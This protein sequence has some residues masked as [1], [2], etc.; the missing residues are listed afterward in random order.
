METATR[1]ALT[2]G[3]GLDTIDT[4]RVVVTADGIDSGELDILEV[5]EEWAQFGPHEYG[6][7]LDFADQV[8]R[9]GRW[10]VVDT[11][12]VCGCWGDEREL[13]AR[14]AYE[15]A[16]LAKAGL[17]APTAAAVI[18]TLDFLADDLG[19]NSV[20]SVQVAAFPSSEDAATVAAIL[21]RHAP[22]FR[23]PVRFVAGAGFQVRMGRWAGSVL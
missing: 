15:A 4:Y 10:A 11:H 3:H 8:R 9:L 21:G 18:R 5:A 7:A 22:H 12:Y 13:T 6:K 19:R 16:A 1:L 23:F 14:P 20:A 17:F 2:H